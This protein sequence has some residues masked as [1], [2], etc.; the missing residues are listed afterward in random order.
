MQAETC[1]MAERREILLDEPAHC[2]AHAD[3]LLENGNP[4]RLPFLLKNRELM[5]PAVKPRS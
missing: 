1:R 4:L 5:L 2:N 3:F